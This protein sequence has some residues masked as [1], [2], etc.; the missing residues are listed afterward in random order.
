MKSKIIKFG[1][2]ILLCII[3]ILLIIGLIHRNS[4]LQ[5]EVSR[6]TANMKAMIAENDNLSNTNM[7]FQLTINELESMNDSISNKMVD[8]LEELKIKP[9]TVTQIQYQKEVITKRD[10]LIL[11]D[12]IFIN[13]TFKLDTCLSDQW[14]STRLHLSYPGNIDINSKF[15][16]EKYIIVHSKKEPI[17]PHKC[18][19]VNFFRRKHTVLEIDVIDK[20]PYVETERQ[21]FVE[22][23]D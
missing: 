7:A 14:S 22:I 5:E 3:T 8:V 12:T 15:N 21:R 9:K 1:I 10:T 20:N 6:T 16:N 13:P 23:I 11:R 2:K 17:R 19:F 4:V 18:K